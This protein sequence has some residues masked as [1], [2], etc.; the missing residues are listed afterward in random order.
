VCPGLQAGVAPDPPLKA[1]KARSY[2]AGIRARP[3]AWLETDVAV[4]RT[5]VIDDIF[6]V[7]PTGTVGVFFQ[8]IGDT[9]RDGVEVGA[10]ARVV[11][12]LSAY[13]NYAYTE[14]TFRN[15]VTLATPRRTG[16]CNAG[17]CTEFVSKGNDLP[18]VPRH[19]LNAGVE[20]QLLPWLSATLSMRYVGTQRLRGDEENV[21]RP[22]SDFVVFG[23]GV[24]ARVRAVSAFLAVDN[25]FDARYETFGTF[26]ANPRAAGTPIERFLTPA[27]PLRVTGGVSYEF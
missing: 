14:A 5:E 13:V 11:R 8:N 16:Q 18:L 10:R 9:R 22:L 7:S 27:P 6:A 26:A 20:Y 1:V 24:K 17:L 3:L 21:E 19:R 2:E 15:D 23:A 25:L 12:G 4:F